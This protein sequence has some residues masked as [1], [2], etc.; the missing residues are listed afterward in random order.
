MMKSSLIRINLIFILLV[1]FIPNLVSA[2]TKTFIKEYTYHAGDEDSRNSSRTIALR[3]VK[4]L[5]LEELG[6]YLE[7]VTEVQNFRLTKDHITTLTAGIVKTEIT[8]EKW[9]GRTYWLKAKISADPGAVIKSIDSLRK[10]RLKT[11]ELEEIRKRS[12]D[13]LKENARLRKELATSKGEKRQKELTEYNQTI[14]DLTAVEWFESGLALERSGNYKDAIDA[15]SNALELGSKEVDIYWHRAFSYKHLGDFR[16]AINDFNIVIQSNPHNYD[17]YSMRGRAFESLGELKQAVLDYSKAIALVPKEKSYY[18]KRGDNYINDATY[19]WIIANYYY[20]RAKAYR[21]L[22]NYRLALIDYDKVVEL[23]GD[24]PS[25]FSVLGYLA[26]FERAVVNAV[27]ENYNQSIKD[28]DQVLKSWPEEANASFYIDRGNV[29]M[30]SGSC[31]S[32]ITD[33]EKALNLK[34]NDTWLLVSL[35]LAHEC[36]KDYK[37]AISNYDKAIEIDAGYA[38][39]YYCK[40]H[41]YFTVGEY[42]QAINNY[43]KA[44]KLDKNKVAFYVGRGVVYGSYL[45]KYQD[46]ISDF[47][48]AVELNPN[49]AGLYYLRGFNYERIAD[50][51]RAIKDYKTAARLGHKSAQERLNDYGVSW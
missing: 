22:E 12:D 16:L 41:A 15:Y 1:L 48:K 27:L 28:Y 47:S 34:R 13:L 30:Q 31:K 40:G 17:A 32:A 26:Y 23:A 11:K 49:D 39:A 50:K 45:R 8:D 37:A 5:L 3:E 2:E 33:F 10:D 20:D 38:N 35:G 42:D 14:K 18:D 6:T 43:S 24:N 44:I 7:S 29:H 19:K 36:I 21:K 51:P 9:D 25:N 4:R 46:A